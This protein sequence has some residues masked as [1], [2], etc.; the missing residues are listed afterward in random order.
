MKKGQSQVNSYLLMQIMVG[1]SV[2]WNY[3][4]DCQTGG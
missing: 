1:I 4:I 2:P 3:G